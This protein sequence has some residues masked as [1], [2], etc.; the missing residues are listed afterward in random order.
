MCV[1]RKPV[2]PQWDRSGKSILSYPCFGLCK[3]YLMGENLHRVSWT[4]PRY[5]IDISLHCLEAQSILTDIC[6]PRELQAYW[7]D[8]NDSLRTLG[9]S[10]NVEDRAR[11]SDETSKVASSKA[12]VEI[13]VKSLTGLSNFLHFFSRLLLLI[14]P[15]HVQEKLLYLRDKYNQKG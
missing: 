1:V 8:I 13:W 7:N 4:F 5:L 15:V 11:R 2:V 14:H 3:V 9:T 12:V 10:P 6:H